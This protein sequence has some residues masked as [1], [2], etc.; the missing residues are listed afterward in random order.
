VTERTKVIYLSHITSF[1]ALIFPVEEVCRRAREAGILTLIDGAHAPG[2][3]PLDL[4]A[5]G[6]DFYAG[7]L[8][9]WLC[10]PKGSGFLHVRPEH[11]D[12]MHAA[13][14]SWGWGDNRPEFGVKQFQ[15]RNEWQGTRD[16]AA[17]LT[18]PAAI[19]YQAEHDWSAV[20]D[21]CHEIV[22]EG[23]NRI[24]ELF[25]LPQICPESRD[26]FV[27]MAT[28]PI[29]TDSVPRLKQVLYDHRYKIEIPVMGHGDDQ[30]VRISIQAY[31]TIDDIDRLLTALREL[32]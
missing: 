21:R 5:I 3:I 7:N 20:R 18:V 26:W 23:R 12:R 15:R 28:C 19:A 8:H 31:N 16:P 25:G 13:I 2:H 1:S 17:Y 4:T 14:V 10:A 27:Q 32:V 22:L 9:K 24:A 29:H 6:A 11:Q 30:Y